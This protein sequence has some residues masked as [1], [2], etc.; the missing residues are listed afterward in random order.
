MSLGERLKRARKATGLNQTEFG[1]ACG[2]SLNGQSNFERGDNI[3]GGAYLQAA[4]NLGVDVN[5]VLTGRAGARD[6]AES[7]LLMR[8]R[9]ASPDVQAA[10]LRSLG[11]ATTGKPLPAVSISGGKQGQVIAGNVNQDSVAISVSGKKR[12]A[13]K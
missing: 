11:V 6:D 12:G 2:V 9:A 3:P 13:R 10:V 1:R 4:A 5:F 8:F 7:E